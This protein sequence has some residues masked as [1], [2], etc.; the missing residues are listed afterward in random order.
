MKRT[1]ANYRKFLFKVSNL[2]AAD[3]LRKT[4]KLTTFE[5]TNNPKITL[6]LMLVRYCGKQS[7]KS[8][9]IFSIARRS[10]PAFCRFKRP[11][12]FCQNEMRERHGTINLR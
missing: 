8:V 6:V 5:G 11:D 2:K 3:F 10:E 1:R 12:L 7:I 9:G 4:A